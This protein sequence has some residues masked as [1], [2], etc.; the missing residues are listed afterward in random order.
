MLTWC[1]QS[2]R[3]SY[4]WGIYSENV[5]SEYWETTSD[6]IPW[7]WQ[8]YEIDT[9]TYLIYDTDI[10]L[11]S[12]SSGVTYGLSNDT[13]L[14]VISI[15]DDLFPAFYTAED[16]KIEPLLRYHNFFD[17]PWT[18]TLQFNPWLAPNNVTRHM[19]RL[20]TSITNVMRS[21]NKKD[22]IPGNAFS[23]ENYV[24][25]RWQWLTLPLGLLSIALIFLSATI[26]KSASERD[27]VGVWKTSAYATLLYGL[28]DE[29]QNKI[30]RSGSTGTPRSKAKELK[31]K[32][33]PNGGWRVSGNLF[34]PFTPKP[35]LY[36]PPPGWI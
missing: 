15:F 12:P 22:M 27:R 34:T 13:L 26:A 21:S 32:L 29:M 3:S 5:T 36:Q 19:E 6:P 10:T 24:D 31:V 9:G 7:P 30:T 17:G 20:A 14:P 8:A 18:R 4:A 23:R 1:V 25:V 35:R 2:I 33:Q 16:E 28:P 11:T